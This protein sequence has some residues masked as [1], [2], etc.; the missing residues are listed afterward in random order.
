M[1]ATE[2]T[3]PPDKMK[4]Q[5]KGYMLFGEDYSADQPSA[6]DGMPTG[7]F[8]LQGGIGS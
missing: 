8:R 6:I 2:F 7:I 5:L 3:A 4:R 1:T